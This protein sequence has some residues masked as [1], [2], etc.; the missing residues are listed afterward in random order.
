MQRY[1]AI[2]YRKLL[3]QVRVLWLYGQQPIFDPIMR[4]ILNPMHFWR[5][6]RILYLEDCWQLEP[7]CDKNQQL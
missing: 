7:K 6:W 5:L 4:P 3:F 2:A 1:Q